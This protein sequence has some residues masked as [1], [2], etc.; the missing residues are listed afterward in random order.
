MTKIKMCGL[1]SSD[2]IAAVNEIRPEYIGFVFCSTSR[3]Y[4]SE[5]KA[6][7][8][9]SLLDDDIIAES[10]IAASRFIAEQ[11]AIEMYPEAQYVE[12]VEVY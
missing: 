7:M 2:D 3:R 1:T 8:L 10:I 11:I 9:K 4:V 12:F 5:E 6:Q